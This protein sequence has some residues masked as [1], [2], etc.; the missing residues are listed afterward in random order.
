MH[1]PQSDA[2]V[3]RVVS[4]SVLFRSA[5][6]A[7]VSV[8]AAAASSSLVRWV[9]RAGRPTLGG[10][11]LVAS[12]THGVLVSFEP[13]A[14]APAGRYLLAAVGLIGGLWSVLQLGTRK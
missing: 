3:E 4:R 5:R 11:L 14:T 13:A 7:L 9:R 8:D 2:D 10:V 1:L 12:A 6:A